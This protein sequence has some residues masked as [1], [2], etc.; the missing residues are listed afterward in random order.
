MPYLLPASFLIQLVPIP[1]P[2]NP[3]NT[4]GQAPNLSEVTWTTSP[5]IF[6]SA[7]TTSTSL[8][9]SSANQGVGGVL[10]VLAHRTQIGLYLIC[11]LILSS[12]QGQSVTAAAICNMYAGRLPPFFSLSGTCNG[13]RCLEA[14]P[15]FLKLKGSIHPNHKKKKKCI[16]PLLI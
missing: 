10:I 7:L 14:Q 13:N 8:S 3:G 4:R 16:Y 5:P 6:C 9:H 1:A 15:G 2:L 12:I 11:F